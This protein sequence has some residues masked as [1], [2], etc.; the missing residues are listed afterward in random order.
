MDQKQKYAKV[1]IHRSTHGLF[2]LVLWPTENVLVAHRWAI[3]R[4]LKTIYLL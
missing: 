1:D 3:A 2:K 4:S